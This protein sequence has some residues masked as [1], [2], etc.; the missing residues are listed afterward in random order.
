MRA[1][2]MAVEEINSDDDSL[3]I[4]FKAS[5]DE[6]T[7]DTSVK[8]AREFVEQDNV[9]LL[10]QGASSSVLLALSEFAA[11]VD[12]PLIGVSATMR[13]I[14]DQCRKQV[15]R[16]SLNIQDE[17]HA[18]AKAVIERYGDDIDTIAGVNPD[19]TF[20][21]EVWEMSKQYYQDE[22]GAEVVSETFPQFGKGN[23][24]NEIQSTMNAD[25]DLVVSGLWAGDLITFMRQGKEVG[26]FESLEVEGDD[27][28]FTA[29]TGANMDVA[30]ALGDGL[31]KYIGVEYY[32][33]EY[34]QTDLN[35]E[36]AR[37][38]YEKYDNIPVGGAALVYGWI[39][40]AK[41]AV[42]QAGGKSTDDIISGL[43]GLS[44]E[45][46][47]GEMNIRPED[48]EGVEDEILVGR[49]GDVGEP[50]PEGTPELDHYGYKDIWT[51]PGEEVAPEITCDLTSE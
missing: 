12:T 10:L 22:I 1:I 38:Y 18:C 47:G 13:P 45:W 7:P 15:F 36:F 3:N 26:F 37:N 40:A 25:P 4:D 24:Q 51:V 21:H 5:D 42:E 16:P 44:Y 32:Y 43:E 29:P 39:Y 50:W 46:P 34:P 35:K 8:R 20:G 23:Y 14:R 41:K 17:A 28:L 48:H 6:G 11:T 27:P 2:E 49:F 9:D 33:Q 30:Q 31:P 19:Y